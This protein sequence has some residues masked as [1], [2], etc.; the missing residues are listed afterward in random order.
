MNLHTT[1]EKGNNSRYSW[2]VEANTYRRISVVIIRQGA[3][4]LICTSPVSKP[5]LSLPNVVRKSRNFWFDS[6]FSG[7]VYN[8]L[9]T[10]NKGSWLNNVSTKYSGSLR[11]RSLLHI[12]YLVWCFADSAMAYSATTVFPAD[13]CAATNT[14]SCD[15]MWIMACFWNGSSSNG[16]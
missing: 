10:S 15:S 5:M 4:V 9:D 11:W 16:H 8:V 6:A 2:S 13:V 1:T 7:E 14:F 3:S 12:S